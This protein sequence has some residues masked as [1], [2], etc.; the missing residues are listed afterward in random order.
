MADLFGNRYK[1]KYTFRKVDWNTYEEKGVY[2]YILDGTI[3]QAVNAEL[4]VTGSLNFEGYEIPDANDLIRIYYS[5]IDDKGKQF[6]R[7]LA[8]LFVGYASLSYENTQKGI[9]AKGT[10]D[11]ASLLTALRN[12]CVGMPYTLKRGANPIYEATRI[13]TECGLRVSAEASSLVLTKDHTFAGGTNKLDIVNW[14]LEAANYLPAY[15]DE[16]GVIQ[17]VSQSAYL[18]QKYDPPLYPSKRLYP[19]ETLYPKE[20]SSRGF[21]FK[22]D[23]QSIMLPEIVATNNWSETPNVV[24]LLHN[25][26]LACIKAYARNISGS[27]ASLDNR[28][29]REETHYE[30]IS[31][32]GTGDKRQALYDLAV[33]KLQELSADVEVVEFKHAYVPIRIYD[34]IIVEYSDMVW[35]GKLTNMVIS[36][37]T[38]AECQTKVERII[39]DEIVIEADAEVIR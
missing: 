5:F 37:D 19:K 30:E 34:P 25:T 38:S 35:E 10:L 32:L 23:E 18:A 31:E 20:G 7:P 1:T 29:N 22:D 16:M 15:P 8:T 28:G 36:L 2:N 14:L 3:E 13:C 12:S 27:K 17:M 33:S 9:K 21:K 24:R 4:K 39:Y 6:K 26:K 11:G